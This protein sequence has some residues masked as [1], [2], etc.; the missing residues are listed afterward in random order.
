MAFSIRRGFLQAF[1]PIT[2]GEY[3]I[4]LCAGDHTPPN[5][6]DAPAQQRREKAAEQ[7]QTRYREGIRRDDAPDDLRGGVQL[8]DECR[9]SAFKKN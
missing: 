7:H 9:D 5:E 3:E 6:A 4:W 2:M 1:V 8:T